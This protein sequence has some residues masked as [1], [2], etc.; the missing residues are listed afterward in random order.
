[1]TGFTISGWMKIPDG[2]PKNIE[3]LSQLA[4]PRRTNPKYQVQPRAV[5]GGRWLM[6]VDGGAV[7]GA[8]WLVRAC[9]SCRWLYTLLF[10]YCCA[11]CAR[12]VL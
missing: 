1:M 11:F 5:G 10:E 6:V 8:L 9:C 12:A 7:A 2:P 4:T 3:R